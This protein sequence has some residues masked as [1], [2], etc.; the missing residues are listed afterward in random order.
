MSAIWNSYSKSEM[1]RRP[2]TITEAPTLLRVVH[3]QAREG[4][5]LHARLAPVGLADDLHPLLDR[6][7]RLLL[8]VHQDGDR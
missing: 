7:Q 6:E 2:R 5:D 3:E 8:G 4:V 1:A